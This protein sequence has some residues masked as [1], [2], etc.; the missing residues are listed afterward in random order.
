V[1]TTTAPASRRQLSYGSGRCGPILIS[2]SEEGLVALL[3]QPV[4]QI[5][6]SSTVV[7]QGGGADLA[8]QCRGVTGFVS[9]HRVGGGARWRC[10]RPRVLLGASSFAQAVPFPVSRPRPA[11]T[12]I[13][14]DVAAAARWGSS[15]SQPERLRSFHSP[16]RSPR[17]S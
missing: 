5:L 11:A 10:E 15:D 17:R 16:A 12:P 6:D 1:S 2:G 9:I 8:H 3:H 4:V 13:S 14:I 7:A